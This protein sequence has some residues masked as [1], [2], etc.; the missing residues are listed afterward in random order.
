MHQ[1]LDLERYPLDKPDTAAYRA[2]VDDGRL[3]IAERGLFNLH[4]LITETALA[5][6]V[7][8]VR[9]G[10]AAHAYTHAQDHNIYFRSEVEGLTARHPALKRSR[11]SNRKICADQIADSLVTGIYRWPPLAAFIADVMEKPELHT[12]DDPLACLNVM[13]YRNGEALNWHFDRSE[14]TTTLLLQAPEA[15]GEFQYR[16]GLRTDDDPN[17]DGVGRFLSGEDGGCETVTL[18][19]GTLNIFKGVNTAHR[20][21]PVQGARERI[22]AVLSYYEKPGVR[23]SDEDRIRFYG[24]A[25]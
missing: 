23:F 24:R 21:S 8:E 19:P 15:G 18:R 11:T 14:F 3:A 7:A 17:Y 10:L 5:Q 9:T 25:A 20:V 4:G 6:C 12:M 2:L 22:I 16:I 13:A 1:L